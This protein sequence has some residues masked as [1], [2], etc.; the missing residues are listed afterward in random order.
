MTSH[1]P[2]TCPVGH[3]LTAGR[4][5]VGWHPCTCP[6]A[7]D[8]GHHTWTCISCLDA[9]QHLRDRDVPSL[10]VFGCDPTSGS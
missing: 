1:P 10:P 9:G 3:T 6:G 7:A 2:L 5:L 8:G 4:V